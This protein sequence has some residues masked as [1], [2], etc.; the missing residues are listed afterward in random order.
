MATFDPSGDTS[1]SQPV[2]TGNDEG[3]VYFEPKPAL[4]HAYA[5]KNGEPK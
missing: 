3:L 1:T 4:D 2:P 5:D